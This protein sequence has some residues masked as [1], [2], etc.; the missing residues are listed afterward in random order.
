MIA[1]KRDSLVMLEVR[2][3]L[4]GRGPLLTCAG[5]TLALAAAP[6]LL[7]LIITWPAAI[8]AVIASLEPGIL[9]LAGLITNGG[10]TGRGS[11]P[12][13]GGGQRRRAKGGAFGPVGRRSTGAWV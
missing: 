3:S 7:P 11:N 6:L 10:R 4:G 2:R 1:M 12:Q 13:G 9:G 5:V 8:E